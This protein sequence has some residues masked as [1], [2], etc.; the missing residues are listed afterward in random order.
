MFT[1]KAIP[2]YKINNEKTSRKEVKYFLQILTTEQYKQNVCCLFPVCDNA[3][4]PYDEPFPH[5]QYAPKSWAP[6]WETLGRRMDLS[7]Q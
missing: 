7:D 4:F 1:E 6:Y 3:I 5:A 2:Q